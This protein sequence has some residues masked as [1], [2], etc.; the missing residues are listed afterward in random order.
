MFDEENE[1]YGYG[2]YNT[3]QNALVP[4]TQYIGESK[5]YHENDH[6]NNDKEKVKQAMEEIAEEQ[7]M[8]KVSDL[9]HLRVVTVNLANEEDEEAINQVEEN[10]EVNA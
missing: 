4:L 6:L 7:G 8:E 1:L 10:S 2:I 9:S 5:G 3:H